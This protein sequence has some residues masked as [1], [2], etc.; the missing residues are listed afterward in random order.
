MKEMQSWRAHQPGNPVYGM[1][2]RHPLVYKTEGED[3]EKDIPERL[4]TSSC[5]GE[6]KEWEPSNGSFE[7]M[8]I[9]A[10]RNFI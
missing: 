10:V 7:Q 6:V 3:N 1:V 4:F 8:T 2:Y 5:E 9:I